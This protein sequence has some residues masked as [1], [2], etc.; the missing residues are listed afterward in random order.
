MYE[1][2]RL[3]LRFLHEKLSDEFSSLFYFLP[4][5]FRLFILAV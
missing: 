2:I 4:F 1:C 3:Y 5:R